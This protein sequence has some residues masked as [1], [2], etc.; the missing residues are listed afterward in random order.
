M[1]VFR[2]CA[3]K[4]CHRYWVARQGQKQLVPLRAAAAQRNCSG[5]GNDSPSRVQATKEALHQEPIEDSAKVGFGKHGGLTYKEIFEAQEQ[6]CD[7]LINN[8]LKPEKGK[9][10]VAALKLAVYVLNRRHSALASFKAGS[11]LLPSTPETKVVRTTP[12]P[13]EDLQQDLQHDVSGA[14]GC[15]VDQN[16]Q[17]LTF[18]LSGRA[19]G[20]RRLTKRDV[21][22]LVEFFGGVVRSA[23]SGKTNYLIVGEDK[24]SDWSRGRAGNRQH[25]SLTL[26]E[27]KARE[28]GIK[29]LR[30]QEVLELIQERSAGVS[31]DKLAVFSLDPGSR[32]N[33]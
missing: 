25:D 33:E 18:V 8:I 15:L 20:G 19:F 31:R 7:W 5:Q 3:R 28:H 4:G 12:P 2:T 27:Q 11:P 17:P 21:G 22:I 23:V 16:G 10:S 9:F 32:S 14:P 30:V 6:Y 29:V 13:L 26:K 24:A 1:L